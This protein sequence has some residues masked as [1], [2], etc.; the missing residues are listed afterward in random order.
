MPLRS[1]ATRS[2]DDACDPLSKR[3]RY[4]VV[5]KNHNQVPPASSRLMTQQLIRGH[6]TF[7]ALISYWRGRSQLSL[8]Q[9]VAI[10]AWALGE[11]GWLDSAVLSRIENARQTRGASLKNLLAFDAINAAVHLWQTSGKQAA[12]ERYGPFS[13]WGVRDE[14][15]DGAHWL[16][17]PD[18]PQHPLEFSDLAEVLV[19]RLTE[20]PYLGRVVLRDSDDG[21]VL[22]ARLSDLLNAAL[23]AKGL[24]PRDATA[25]L[26]DVYPSRDETRRSRLVALLMGTD[27]LTRDEIAEEIYAL[28]EALRQLRGL[29]MGGYGPEDLAAELSR[30]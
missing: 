30:A 23:A 21:E 5:M 3:Q 16:P 8:N 24:A 26:L 13:G 11:A 20:L 28:S 19:G 18:Q 15:L 29:P 14:W 1:S 27:Q 6:A 4:T 25:A 7:G 12:L 9:M 22:S 10:A 17:V 2:I